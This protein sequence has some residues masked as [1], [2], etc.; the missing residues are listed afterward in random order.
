MENVSAVGRVYVVV[1]SGWGGL[2]LGSG[3]ARWPTKC[4]FGTNW[5]YRGEHRSLTDHFKDTQLGTQL[6]GT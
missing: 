3:S 5:V 4:H 1:F 2:G 6:D